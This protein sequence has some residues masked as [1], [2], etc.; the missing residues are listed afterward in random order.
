M[1]W[2]ADAKDKNIISLRGFEYAPAQ[3]VDVIATE[4][5]AAGWKPTEPDEYPA[6]VRG[7]VP[8]KTEEG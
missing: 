3:Q 8:G 2:V 7:T 6:D 1:K 5:E 4:L